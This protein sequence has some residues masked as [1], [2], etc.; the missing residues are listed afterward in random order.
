MTDSATDRDFI[1]FM[2][3][4]WPSLVRAAILMG[5][6]T[7][8]SQDIAQE[9]MTRCF[10]AWDRV[11]TADDPRA[12]AHVV[13]ANCVRTHYRRRKFTEVAIDELPLVSYDETQ[14]L[15]ERDALLRA[16]QRLPVQQ[17]QVVVLRYFADLNLAD[18]ARALKTTVGTVKSRVHRA[19]RALEADPSL[20][21]ELDHE[22]TETKS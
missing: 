7:H 15:I 1:E 9:A 22:L 10:Q 14:P 20:S 17:R 8:V 18:T 4:T 2:Q 11:S 19:L 16:L 3:A 6:P 21:L 5:T 12:Y 13:L